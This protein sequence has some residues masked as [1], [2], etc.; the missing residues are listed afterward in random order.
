M[1]WREFAVMGTCQRCQV[2]G[3]LTRHHILRGG[4]GPTI[5]LCRACHDDVDNELYRKGVE[6]GMMVGLRVAMASC[7]KERSQAKGDRNIARPVAAATEASFD[8]VLTHL[9]ALLHRKRAQWE[10]HR[11]D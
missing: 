5:A 9:T 10:A 7:R 2:V 4:Y 1:Q 6:F 11:N 8:R 3:D